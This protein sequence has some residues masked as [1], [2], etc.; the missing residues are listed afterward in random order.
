MAP[1][2]WIVVAAVAHSHDQLTVLPLT[3]VLS[4]LH[5]WFASRG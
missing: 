3:P 2:E 4:T 5:E 1:F